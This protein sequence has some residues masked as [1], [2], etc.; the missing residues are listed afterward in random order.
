[1]NAFLSINTFLSFIS[2]SLLTSVA[3]GYCGAF[4]YYFI[5]ENKSVHFLYIKYNDLIYALSF[6][7]KK[8]N[9][10]SSIFF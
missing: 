8:K 2:L 10:Q 4:A 9:M 6:Q 3:Y 5:N 7:K 1:M